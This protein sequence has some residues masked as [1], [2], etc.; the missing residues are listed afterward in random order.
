MN[1]TIDTNEII[2]KIKPYQIVSFDIFDTLLKRDLDNPTDLFYILQDDLKANFN[3]SLSDFHDQRIEAER[4]AR[5]NQAGEV[6]LDE[7][8]QV[9]MA[10]TKMND[11]QISWAK[12]REEQLEVQYCTPNLNLLPVYD[13]CRKEGKQIIIV[14][15]MYLPRPVITKMLNKSGITVFDKLW[16]SNESRNTKAEGTLFSEV[17]TALQVS[18]SRIIHIGDNKRSDFYQANRQGWQAILIPTKTNQ[19]KYPERGPLSFYEKQIMS[20]AN[21]RIMAVPS[22]QRLGYETMG[23]LLYGYTTWL[24]SELR[25]AGIKKIFFLARDGQIMKKAFDLVNTNKEFESHYLYASRRALQVPILANE[26]MDFSSY[27]KRLHWPPTV[28]VNYFLY[29]LGIEDPRIVADLKAKYHIDNDYAVRRENLLTDHQLL[30]LFS[31]ERSLIQKNAHDELQALLAYLQEEKVNG[32]IGIVDIGWRGNMQLNLESLLKEQ[33][34]DYQVQGYYVGV[35]PTDNHADRIQMKGYIFN[36]QNN[37]VFQIEKTVNSLFEQIFMAS[38]GSVKRFEESENGTIEP[39]LYPLEQT[40]SYS[41]SL[42]INYQQGALKFVEDFSSTYGQLSVN[43]EFAV[44]G[45]LQQ[46]INPTLED[47]LE[48][49]NLKFKDVDTKPL[50]ATKGLNIVLHPQKFAQ[51][52]KYSVWKEGFLRLNLKGNYNL[53]HIV[54]QITKFRERQ[55][56]KGL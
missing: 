41:K 8:Y 56:R 6:T 29:A 27:V 20:F 3:Y 22:S 1:L 7:I 36:Q 25:K 49:S 45:V 53:H 18:P 15:D 17:A 26:N 21:N 47:A 13:Y 19:L 50:I 42:L 43:G 39:V 10:T 46:F 38:H 24:M 4:Q 48:W 34:I 32:S 54:N 16:I 11:D 44:A 33:H 12:Q 55:L 28:T 23:P 40:D 51:A 30:N 2:K 31:K 52:Y 9:L 5:L 14:S 35:T 37:S